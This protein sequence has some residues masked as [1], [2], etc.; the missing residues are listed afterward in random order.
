ME[1]IVRV[2][3]L[4]ILLVIIRTGFAGFDIKIDARKD[5]VYQNLNRPENGYIQLTPEDYLPVCGPRP[6]NDQDLSAKIWMAWDSVYF[7]VYAEIRDDII[8]VN[9]EARPENDCIEI[10]IDPDPAQKKL[11]GV[12][13][14]RLTALDTLAADNPHGV[15]NLYSEGGL[16]SVH[17]SAADYA[18]RIT[19]E[20][21]VVELRLKWDWIHTSEKH[22]RGETGTHFG[23]GFNIHDNDS[24]NRDGSVNW[25]A[26]KADQMWI[27]PLLLGTAVLDPDHVVR[28]VKRN[29]I[30]PD[31]GPGQTYLSMPLLTKRRP[32]TIEPENWRYHRGDNPDWAKYDY[33]DHDWELII[34]RL[35]GDRMP[36]TGWDGKGWFRVELKVDSSVVGYPL[37][38]GM[39]QTGAAE[40]YLDGERIFRFGRVAEPD[41]GEDPHWER[42][43]RYLSFRESGIHL[44]AVRYSN[45]DFGRFHRY[46]HDAGFQVSF[47]PDLVKQIDSRVGIV[48]MLSLYQIIFF[49]IPLTL[50]VIHLFLFAFYPR[51]RENLYFSIAMLCWAIVIFTDFNGP[52]YEDF[53]EIFLVTRIGSTALPA[54][55]LFGLLMLYQS[56]YKRIPKIGYVFILAA[57]V[58]MIWIQVDRTSRMLGI[59]LYLMIGLATLEVLRLLFVPGFRGWKGRWITLVG[60][61]CFMTA[62]IYQIVSS[63]GYLP[64]MGEYNIMY[65]YGLLIL[66]ISASIDLS[67]DFATTNRDLEARLEEVKS[68]SQK[69][70]EQERRFREEE[71][72]RKLLEAD[73]DRKTKELEE[74]RQLQ[75]SMLPRKIPHLPHLE[76]AALM[77]TATEVG[78][79]YYDFYHD[80]KGTLTV[81]IGDATG[82]GMKAGTMVAAIKSLFAA[83]SNKLDMPRF[84]KRCTE[85][86]RDMHLGNIYMAMM[87]AKINGG[88]VSVAAAGMP[89][90]YLYRAATGEVEEIV[91]KGM[92]LGAHLG[93]EYKTR[94]TDIHPG[95]TLLFMTD[96]YA[97]LFN[98]KKEV[99][100][101][102]RVKEVFRA[103]A[104]EAPQAVIDHL[105]RA[106]ETWQNGR[107]QQDD[108]TFVV[109]KYVPVGKVT[110]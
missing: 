3:L 47:H 95:D 104:A 67:R 37:A 76:I 29:S 24:D 53:Q 32:H 14:A 82:H 26:G 18:R 105:L 8:R 22:I 44:L 93:L 78:G 48:R 87:L 83:F 86:I 15:D 51:A 41:S 92:P 109:I 61:V 28:L 58:F 2:L 108:F 94:K 88:T 89:P 11:V 13:N 74:A 12:V 100:D 43:P 110:K 35:P 66:A 17:I 80:T 33:D 72:A 107:K 20:G 27:N 85:I 4:L 1:D 75:L 52:M 60:F 5:T 46:N 91:I 59:G 73:N 70:L 57:V 101:Y 36:A 21:Y 71:I 23:I 98:D 103:H 69:A 55:I 42:N 49:I 65:V 79:D 38:F 6:D 62:L 64:R 39:Y 96:G 81:A 63:M 56:L 40:I 97:E 90:L 102:P 68:L 54:A 25:S 106:G 7:Y 99:M 50:A 16:D 77:K 19:P 30:D 31:A 84:F 10:K 9:N 45:M 34:S